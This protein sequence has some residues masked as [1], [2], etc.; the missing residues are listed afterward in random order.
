[1][2]S[3]LIALLICAG[4]PWAGPTHA[5]EPNWPD[6]LAIGT[7]S[8]GGTYYV[9]GEGLARLLT[10]ALS[11]PV[12]RLP[13]EG[14]VQN[15]ELIE[16]AEAKLGFV[17]TGIAP[18]PEPASLILLGSGIVLLGGRAQALY[19]RQARSVTEARRR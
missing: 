1:M 10:R 5:G 15:I 8:P 13:T 6:H 16:S 14:P 11:L 4:M 17:T 3:S 19:R 9:Y 18:T 2:R 7:A 12:M